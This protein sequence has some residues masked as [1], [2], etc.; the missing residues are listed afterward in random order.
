MYF[1]YCRLLIL[2]LFCTFVPLMKKIFISLLA[3]LY[4]GISSGVAME[5]HY[6]MGNKA[7]MELYGSSSDKCG[8][9]GMTD[10]K[11]GCCHDE[12]KFYKL[13]DS[14][15]LVSNDF[16]FSSNIPAVISEYFVYDWQLSE[17][18]N[19]FS[20]NYFIPPDF[21]KPPLRI[22]NGVFRI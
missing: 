4:L 14:H 13:N 12:F 2:K 18:S 15:K 20:N 1:R 7:G 19:L 16:G 22:M 5:L 3:I 21:N 10:S 6:C 8:K 17:N 9:C 11:S